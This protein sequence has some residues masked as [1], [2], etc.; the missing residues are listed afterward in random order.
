MKSSESGYPPDLSEDATQLVLRQAE[1]STADRGEVR[2]RTDTRAAGAA[3]LAIAT[4]HQRDSLLT[5]NYAHMANP[6]VQA[7]LEKLCA[8]MK[9]VAPRWSRPNRSPRFASDSPSAGV[10]DHGGPDTRRNP[11]LPREVARQA[12][13]NRRISALRPQARPCPSPGAAQGCETPQS[14]PAQCPLRRA[15]IPLLPR[16]NRVM[17]RISPMADLTPARRNSAPLS[18]SRRKHAQSRPDAARIRVATA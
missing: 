9:W 4:L 11:A 12:R 6:L 14:T 2:D 10:H 7:Q 5:W 15:R 18:N 17:G 13:R 16:R 1:L 3:H 8:E